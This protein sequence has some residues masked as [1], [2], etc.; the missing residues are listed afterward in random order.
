MRFAST[1][2]L[3]RDISNFNHGE[4]KGWRTLAHTGWTRNSS[5]NPLANILWMLRTYLEW[6]LWKLMKLI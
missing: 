2:K 6:K 5:G 4:T 3:T 1:G